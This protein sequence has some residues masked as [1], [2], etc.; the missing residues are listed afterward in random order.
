MPWTKVD[1][2]AQEEID[3][4][5]TRFQKKAR[6]LVDESVGREAAKVIRSLGWNVKYVEDVS[7][8]GRADEDVFAFAWK[9]DRILLTHDADFLNDRRFPPH[10]NP[11]VVIVPGGNG[12]EKALLRALAFILSVIAPFREG[13]RGTKM[14]VHSDGNWTIVMQDD[15]TGMMD[16]IRMRSR[17]NGPIEKWQ[18]E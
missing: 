18:S 8:Q 13:Y 15:Q 10:R 11:G 7:L 1:L 5:V 9:D 16:R 2:P 4:F 3:A 12:N 14:I 17:R 6:F